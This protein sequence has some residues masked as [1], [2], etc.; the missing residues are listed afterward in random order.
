MWIYKAHRQYTKPAEM[1]SKDSK[2]LLDTP[3]VIDFGISE[4][5]CLMDSENGK[6]TY[7]RLELRYQFVHVHHNN[8]IT[9]DFY[10][11]ILSINYSFFGY[12]FSVS[13]FFMYFLLLY[14]CTANKVAHIVAIRLSNILSYHLWYILHFTDK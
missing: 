14:W 5:I 1:R 11:E 8:R 10:A 12:F 13:L 4:K 7:T 6:I 2:L 9:I 3:I